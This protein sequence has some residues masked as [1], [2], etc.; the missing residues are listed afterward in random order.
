LRS[1]LRIEENVMTDMTS[2]AAAFASPEGGDTTGAVR[3]LALGRLNSTRKRIVNVLAESGQEEVAQAALSFLPGKGSA[4]RP[5]I[6]L[7]LTAYRN[8]QHGLAALQLA[9]ACA[10]M[11]GRGQINARIETAQWLYLDG[12]LTALK[13][14]CSLNA[15][16]GSISICSDLGN[17]TYRAS[18][19][20][21][22]SPEKSA[23]GPWCAFTSGG[24]CPRYITVSGL[25]HSVEGFP[26]ISSTPPQVA[27]FNPVDQWPLPG[28]AGNAINSVRQGWE[29]I[30]NHAPVYGAWVANT[31]SGCLLI[32]PSGTHS[33]QSGSSYDHPGLIAIEPPECPLFCGEILVHECSHQQLLIYTMV[34]PLVMPGSKETSYSPIK[35]AHRSIDRVLTGAHAVG[36]MIVYYA[37]LRQTME[38]DPCSQQRFDRHRDWFSQDYRPALDRSE[39]LT[40][41]GRT[42]W[43]SLCTAVDCATGAM[44]Q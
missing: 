16:G 9:A 7:A 43:N 25:R 24:L 21:H 12:W 38:L 5:E 22:W 36:N 44:E 10:G 27:S 26:W 33:A 17:V 40:E 1:A 8:Q 4:W 41:A 23:M 6:G 31:A 37:T 14:H 3:T 30:I 15:H 11:G 19:E 18:D 34:A 29:V 32:D 2:Y 42:L 13:G 39:S 20:N 28:T 35:R